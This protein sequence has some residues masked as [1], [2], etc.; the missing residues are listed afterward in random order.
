MSENTLALQNRRIA[1]PETRQLDVLAGL[2]ERRG[3]TVMRCPLVNILDVEDPQPVEEWINQAVA[4][5]FDDLILLT[6]EGLRRL[7]G[8]AERC[9]KREAF[10]SALE[11]MRTITRGPKPAKVL[12]E[13]GLKPGLQAG[14]ATTPGLIDTLRSEPM[15]GR[16]VGVQL[17][18]QEPNQLLQ[19]Y[20]RSAGCQVCTVA[21]YR[22]ANAAEDAEVQQ[23]VR[24]LISGE[25]D[26]VCF[27]SSP[28]IRRLLS[29]AA[30][31]GLESALR[32]AL[33]TTVVAAVGPVV[34]DALREQQLP[35]HLMPQSSWFMKPLVQAL[36]DHWQD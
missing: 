30:H 8:V 5:P 27:T 9:G 24:R 13:L 12:R 20:L 35:V 28:Q 34:A 22:Y 18:G 1:I 32:E 19:D 10:V 2:L 6:G 31:Q 11:Q 33:A 29:V 7:L 16:R 21:P 23:L 14:I 3:A 36:V 15:A 4:D 26:A 25:V 17:Y